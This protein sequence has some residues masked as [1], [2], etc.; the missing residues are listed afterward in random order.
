MSQRRRNQRGIALIWAAVVLFVMVGIVGLSLD[1]GKLALNV[2]QM[3][4]AGDAAALAGA[5]I[6]KFDPEGAIAR[7]H[8]YGLANYAEKLPVTLSMARQPEPFSGTEDALDIILGRWVRQNYEFFP[9]LDAP[10][11]VKV[12]VRRR[13][14]LTAE[15]PALSL[16]FGPIFGTS[17]VSA[18]RDTVAWCFDYSGAALI[19]LDPN[20]VPGLKVWGN[21][22]VNVEDGGI[23]VNSTKD[24]A[25]YVGGNAEIDCGQLNSVG[26]AEAQNGWDEHMA[27]PF[28]VNTNET[29]G[30]GPIED[31]VAAAMGGINELDL[32]TDTS[33]N[34]IYGT[35]LNPDGTTTKATSA[36]IKGSCTLGPGYYPGGV[37]MKGG[38]TITLEPTLGWNPA[39]GQAIYFFGGVGLIANN[40]ELTGH[41]VTIYVTEDTTAKL[42]LGGNITVDITSPGDEAGTSV[43]GLPGIGLWVD[44]DNP[45]PVTL[46]G[47]PG[48]GVMGTMYFPDSFVQCYGTPGK[49]APQIIAGSMEIFG[50]V[51]VGV[52]YDQRN[53]GIRSYRSFIVK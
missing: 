5:Q 27:Q 13:E 43:D 4:N 36:T 32:P 42:D 15:T 34:Y 38:P 22:K 39:M 16:V 7:A 20:A 6:V 1:W 40:G 45:N 18:T 50:N 31:P 53:S 10:N 14:G 23:H 48:E 49:G 51:N 17:T 28:P 11:A 9:T 52:N 3:Q 44:P 41:G 12:I 24:P 2:G 46:N 19:C 33:G 35:I 37:D 21:G 47:C 30:V 25:V 29:M 26:D 8:E